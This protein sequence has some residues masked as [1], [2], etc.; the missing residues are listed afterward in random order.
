MTTPTP[1]AFNPLLSSI[2]GP[3]AETPASQPSVAERGVGGGKAPQPTVI[4]PGTVPVIVGGVLST[5]VIVWVAVAVLP[6]QSAT[7]QVR[8][9]GPRPQAL[10]PLLSS[11]GR[12]VERVQLASQPSEAESGAA[13]GKGLPQLM[14]VLG[15]EGSRIEG[16]VVSAPPLFP[17]LV[18]LLKA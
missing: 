9:M 18:Q 11:T 10:R 16:G 6:A 17:V 7:D 3:V 14:V 12:P 5:K 2:G 4:G 13:T 15:G 8:M 1:Q